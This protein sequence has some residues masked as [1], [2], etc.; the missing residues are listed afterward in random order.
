MHT[1]LALVED[2]VMPTY[3]CVEHYICVADLAY[4]AFTYAY[5]KAV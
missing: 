1:V 2:N 4:T 5:M 3:A